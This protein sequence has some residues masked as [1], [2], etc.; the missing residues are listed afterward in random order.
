MDEREPPEA[1]PTK[2]T[3]TPPPPEECKKDMHAMV[4]AARTRSRLWYPPRADTRAKL[5]RVYRYVYT[6]LARVRKHSDFTPVPVRT[7]GTSQETV[8]TLL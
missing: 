4:K 7:R 1:W 3:L 6:F 5:E 2:K 8:K